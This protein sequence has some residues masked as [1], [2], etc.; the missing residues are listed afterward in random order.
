MYSQGRHLRG[1]EGAVAPPPQGKRKKEKKKEKKKKKKKRGK[2]EKK[3][4]KR[5]KGTMNNV[6][7]LHIKCCFSN[8]FSSPVAL[9]NLKKNLAPK[10]KLK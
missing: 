10:K 5:K 8:F 7:L 1:A 4:E 2:K 3:R 9:K 6:K